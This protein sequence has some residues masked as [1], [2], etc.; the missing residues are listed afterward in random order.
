MDFK[1]YYT[2]I[3]ESIDKKTPYLV[4]TIQKHFPEWTDE[5]VKL[6]IQIISEADPIAEK[7]NN[8]KTPFVNQILQWF[9]HK[10]IR[11][12]E[13]QSTIREV[14]LKY[15]EYKNK[16]KDIS[17]YSSPGEIRKDIERIEGEKA[18]SLDYKAN[19]HLDFTQG[20]LKVYRIDDW[21]QG[22]ICFADS[23]WCVQ[24]QTEF[25]NYQPPFYMVTEMR[26]SKE[27]RFALLHPASL[28]IKDVHDDTITQTEDVE[29]LRP[30][31]NKVFAGV[32]IN[33]MLKDNLIDFDDGVDLVR[34]L[35]VEQMAQSPKFCYEYAL[36]LS[37]EGVDPEDIIINSIKQSPAYAYRYA[38]DVLFERWPEAEPYI[39]KNP[40]YAAEYAGE[41][42]KT[43]WLAA[44]PII[45]TEPH[46]WEQYAKHFNIVK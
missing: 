5:K 25:D 12:P 10:K 39:I 18:D 34:F 16:L 30:I 42:M 27:R 15:I 2:S 14:L 26:G 24:E 11:L 33:Q 43:R 38:K 9:I 22:K 4:K 32:N 40:L 44:E 35:S 7:T 6:F 13:D 8:Q 20:N 19:A 45:K 23:G 1:T 3:E 17:H 21:N 46:L 28:S 41:V 31:F 29:K 37:E 36:E